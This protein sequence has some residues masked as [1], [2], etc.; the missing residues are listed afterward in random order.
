[1]RGTYAPPGLPQPRQG[2]V[3]QGTT[4]PLAQEPAALALGAPMAQG[5]PQTRRAVVTARLAMRAPPGLLQP[6]LWIACRGTIPRQGQRS[7]LLVP[8]AS[9]AP[10]HAYPP[11]P[12]VGRALLV[13]T[14]LRGLW[15]PR[16]TRAPRDSTPHLAPLPASPAPE[17]STALGL[18]LPPLPPALVTAPRATRAHRGLSPPPPSRAPRA[19]TP[20]LG[21]RRAPSVLEAPT[22]LGLP[23]PPQTP[24]TAPALLAT[25]RWPG[26]RSA[27]CVLQGSSAPRHPWA[28]RNA[29][30]RVVR[31]TTVPRDR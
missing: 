2:L 18:P 1:M 5:A 10:F 25:T 6:L 24:A 17:A 13:T 22:A 21:K 31:A 7:A 19:T 8:E 29:L 4:P 26:P 20:S 3:R 16:P 9:T 15:S 30:G 11:M 12:A 27:L 23:W 14:A 28:P